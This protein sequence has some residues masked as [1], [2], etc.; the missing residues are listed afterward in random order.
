MITEHDKEILL[1]SLAA[2]TE[3]V[4]HLAV[5]NDVASVTRE[6]KPIMYT[7]KECSEYSGLSEYTIRTWVR[8]RKVFSIRAGEGKKGKILISKSSF[9]GYLAKLA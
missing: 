7:I 9:D 4:E 1:T 5:E 3:V 2:F 8:Q 6:P